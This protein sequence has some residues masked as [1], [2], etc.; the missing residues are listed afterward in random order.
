MDNFRVMFTSR[1]EEAIRK[2]LPPNPRKSSSADTICESWQNK[3]LDYLCSKCRNKG[4]IHTK[5]T[6]DLENATLMACH[7][8][9]INQLFHDIQVLIL[10]DCLII[11]DIRML[12]GLKNLRVLHIYSSQ[13]IG[14]HLKDISRI[15]QLR[16]IHLDGCIDDRYQSD[17][18]E[19]TN[20]PN[21]QRLSIN[22]MLYK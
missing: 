12:R 4:K 9:V 7:A 2:K 6:L 3:A 14:I 17:I 5:K 18:T 10:S 22:N 15:G 19:L 16:E 21:L 1:S 13:E 11:L 20:M 8:E